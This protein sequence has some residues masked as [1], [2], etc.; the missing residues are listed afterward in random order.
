[1]S[2][3]QLK[4]PRCARQGIRLRRHKGTENESIQ[5][6]KKN[7]K[8]EPK[9]KMVNVRRVCSGWTRTIAIPGD[10]P[11]T[12]KQPRASHKHSFCSGA[13]CSERGPPHKQCFFSEGSFTIPSSCR[14]HAA[15]HEERF[16]AFEDHV[17]ARKREASGVYNGRLRQSV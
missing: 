15:S 2:R 13:R 4:C 7:H 16:S 6:K 1:M 17:A 12:T 9:E 14:P 10:S 3:A 11:I 5:E 8:G